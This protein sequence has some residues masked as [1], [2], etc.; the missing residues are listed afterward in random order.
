MEKHVKTLFADGK[1]TGD[2]TIRCTD[3]DFTCH[4][5]VVC[6]ICQVLE[7]MVDYARESKS[8]LI[9]TEY[10]KKTMKYLISMLYDSSLGE[11]EVFSKAIFDESDAEKREK[12]HLTFLLEYIKARDYFG[13]EY[14]I[15]DDIPFPLRPSLLVHIISNLPD[16]SI[17]S[18]LKEKLY[19]KVYA[20]LLTLDLESEMVKNAFENPAISLKIAG[21]YKKKLEENTAIL[22]CGVCSKKFVFKSSSNQS[23]C[24]A[25]ARRCPT[26]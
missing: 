20:S 4:S 10:T 17:Y 14:G 2:L 26:Q 6:C 5:F 16:L 9:V 18:P 23:Y 11:K 3:G 7:K 21:M 12:F 22:T 15:Y 25:C 13:I 19:N 1:N 8:T 24:T